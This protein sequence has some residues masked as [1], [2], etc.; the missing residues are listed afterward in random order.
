MLTTTLYNDIAAPSWTVSRT[1]TYHSRST[2]CSSLLCR[3]NVHTF[4]TFHW[5]IPVRGSGSSE[6]FPS[7][8]VSGPFLPH[9]PGFH[10]PFDSVLPP[11]PESSFWQLLLCFLFHFF[12]FLT[13]PNHCNLFFLQGLIISVFDGMVRWAMGVG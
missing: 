10:V 1:P 8:P 3:L 5:R 2:R 9:L 11:Q 7:L 13:R 4:L 12:F 6:T